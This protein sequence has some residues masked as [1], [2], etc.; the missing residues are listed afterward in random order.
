VRVDVSAREQV[1]IGPQEVRATE[2]GTQIIE[3]ALALAL[4]RASAA[5]EWGVVAQLA[6]ELEARRWVVS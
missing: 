1:A 6:R 5:N 3:I 2:E 4:M